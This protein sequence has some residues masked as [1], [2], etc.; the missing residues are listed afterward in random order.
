MHDA[1]TAGK[2]S[3]YEWGGMRMSPARMPCP[4]S[5]VSAY[6]VALGKEKKARQALTSAFP[7]RR[8]GEAEVSRYHRGWEKLPPISSRED[9]PR[10]LLQVQSRYC[11]S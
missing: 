5:A 4:V 6:Y 1:F 9:V 7:R 10:Y 8:A 11:G 2:G 3:K